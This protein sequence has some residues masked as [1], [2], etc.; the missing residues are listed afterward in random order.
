LAGLGRGGGLLG[1]RLRR[2]PELDGD[3]PVVGAVLVAGAADLGVGLDVI[4]ALALRAVLGL[5]VDLQSDVVALGRVDDEAL[6]GRVDR[7][8]GALVGALGR[9]LGGLGLGGGGGGGGAGGA[10]GGGRGRGGGA[11]GGAAGGALGVRNGS[12]RTENQAEDQRL[13]HRALLCQ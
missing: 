12:E 9:V 1:L 2:R 4:P 11:A 5:V 7:S 8:D 3:R 13:A 6:G 10:G